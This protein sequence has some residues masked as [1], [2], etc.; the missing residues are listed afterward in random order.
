MTISICNLFWR[1]I[2]S[3]LN[4]FAFAIFVATQYFSDAKEKYFFKWVLG[5]NSSVIV[6]SYYVSMRLSWWTKYFWYVVYFWQVLWMSFS[7]AI[8][9]KRHFPNAVGCMFFTLYILSSGLD[10]AW[11]VF[12]SRDMILTALI[13][14]FLAVFLKGVSLV[15]AYV[16][17]AKYYNFDRHSLWD[18]WGFHVLLFNGIAGVI[19][20]GIY[21]ALIW[22]SIVLTYHSGIPEKSSTTISLTLAYTMLIIWFVLE[23]S[24]ILWSTRFTFSIYPVLMVTLVSSLLAN[25]NPQSRNFIMLLVLLGV[26]VLFLVCHVI[27]VVSR[28][29]K[30]RRTFPA[31]VRQDLSSSFNIEF[32]TTKF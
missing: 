26:S 18:F 4:L 7:V 24:I 29:A 19:V 1:A 13:V 20:V 10:I 16:N 22:L 25:W 3:L 11:V 5:D 2:F 17:F 9:F 8:L 32:M 12:I 30:A 15:L 27:R 6:S 31:N 28:L 14:I 23:T 21:N